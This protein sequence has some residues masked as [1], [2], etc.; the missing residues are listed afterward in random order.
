MCRLFGVSNGD[1]LAENIAAAREMSGLSRAALAERLQREGLTNW[2][3]TTVTRV[4]TG[5][6]EVRVSELS[7]L[8][9]VFGLS[10]DS[11]LVRPEQMQRLGRVI[12]A[13]LRTTNAR[14]ELEAAEKEL[15][16]AHDEFR[17]TMLTDERVDQ[18]LDRPVSELLR[19]IESDHGEH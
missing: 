17:A 2:H 1:H 6:R 19:A 15:Q 11:L 8:A 10:R 16:R 13:Y 14:A 3:A 7:A 18:F 12:R 5:Q 4:E 9:R